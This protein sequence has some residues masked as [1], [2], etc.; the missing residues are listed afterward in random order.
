[1][2]VTILRL[3]PA[4]APRVTF[5]PGFMGGPRAFE[6]LAAH[7]PDAFGVRVVTLPGHGDRSAIA[8]G[9]RFE[10]LVALVGA[11]IDEGTKSAVEILVGYS[12]G[13]R[14]ALA[15]ALAH[16]ERFAHVV[17]VGADLGLVDDAAR[18]SRAEEDEARARQIEQAGI[19]AFLEAW[20]ALPLFATQR[21]L[22]PEALAAQRRM[23][24]ANTAE[25]LA[26][27]LRRLG[28]GQMPDLRPQL[29]S[30][31]LPI[32]FVAGSLDAKFCALASEGARIAPRGAWAAFHG[33]GHN[34]PLEAPRRLAKLVAERAVAPRPRRNEDT[35]ASIS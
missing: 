24:L 8:P 33:V 7:L 14:V 27:A 16:P 5:I 6:A 25:G 20:E 30:S 17:A 19:A 26:F 1:M 22:G 18:R 28:T 13:G 29:A 10:E 32:T 3:G 23:R 34:V 21:A 15:A 31:P 4:G 11:E 12:M 2:T 35:D 9:A